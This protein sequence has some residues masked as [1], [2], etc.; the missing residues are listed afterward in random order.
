MSDVIENV[1]DILLGRVIEPKGIGV[2][3]EHQAVANVDFLM[4][5]PTIRT[6]NENYFRY[7]REGVQHEFHGSSS[8][9]ERSKNIAINNSNTP[10]KKPRTFLIFPPKLVLMRRKWLIR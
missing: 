3:V 4:N 5:T 9:S 1:T 8:R 10:R 2:D 7:G 6:Y